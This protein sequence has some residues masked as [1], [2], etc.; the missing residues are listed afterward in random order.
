MGINTRHQTSEVELS[1]LS[2]IISLSLLI[3]QSSSYFTLRL[4]QTKSFITTYR[5]SKPSSRHT[6]ARGSDKNTFLFSTLSSSLSQIRRLLTMASRMIKE[7]RAARNER[8]RRS[9]MFPLPSYFSSLLLFTPHF[10]HRTV[11]ISPVSQCQNI[12]NIMLQTKHAN[13]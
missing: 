12:A 3:N 2:S 11:S 10:V 1:S 7:E 5:P 6:T 8:L 9:G 4:Q 13:I